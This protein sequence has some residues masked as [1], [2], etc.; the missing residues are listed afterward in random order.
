MIIKKLIENPKKGSLAFYPHYHPLL[1][2]LVLSSHIVTVLILYCDCF[3]LQ[4][5]IALVT[6]EKKSFLLSHLPALIEVALRARLFGGNRIDE[7]IKSQHEE[8]AI[9]ES[10]VA[11][12]E[13][14]DLLEKKVGSSALLGHYAEIQR[15]LQATKAE[16]KRVL[17]SE[18]VM[19]PK[20]YAVRKVC[21]CIDYIYLYLQHCNALYCTV[22]SFFL[23]SPCDLRLLYF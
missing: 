13:L 9:K 6:I 8:E 20:G 21:T 16:K 22:Q 7:E 17:A 23:Q 15:R 2:F 12:T 3:N 14:L 10:K 18:A 5:F 19:D 1:L 4:V 11:A